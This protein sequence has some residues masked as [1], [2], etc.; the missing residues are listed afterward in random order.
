MSSSMPRKQMH[1][2]GPSALL[3]ATGTPNDFHI[4]RAV[5]SAWPFDV[6]GSTMR[7]SSKIVNHF[8]DSSRCHD[9]VEGIG[10]SSKNL[11]G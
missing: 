4:S 1:V 3:S 2:V 11:R 6:G 9:S 5:E 8:L 7:K 10:Q